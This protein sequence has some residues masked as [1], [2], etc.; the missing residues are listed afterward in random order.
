MKGFKI[1]LSLLRFVGVNWFRLGQDTDQ[2]RA[3]VNVAINFWFHKRRG[4]C[5]QLSVDCTI[6][7]S[8]SS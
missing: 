8:R 7:G 4:I 6:S 3:S 1:N 2:W 5:D